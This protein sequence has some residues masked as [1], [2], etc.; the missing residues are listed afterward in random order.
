M[1]MLSDEQREAIEDGMVTF[2][3]LK[4]ELGGT[5]YGERVTEIR[6]T[7][8]M[9][10]YSSGVQDTMYSIDDLRKKPLKDAPKTDKVPDI[11][12]DDDDSDDI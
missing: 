1:D 4:E 8:L 3:Q 9:K 10:G 6:L 11:F 12:G 7:G 2:E 5:T